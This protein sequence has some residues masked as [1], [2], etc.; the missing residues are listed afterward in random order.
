MRTSSA[1]STTAK[2]HDNNNESL[3]I[4]RRS[5]DC[6]NGRPKAPG[7][8][9][10]KLEWSADT[11]FASS[12]QSACVS[13]AI[14]CPDWSSSLWPICTKAQAAHLDIVV[15]MTND[16]GSRGA[17]FDRAGIDILHQVFPADPA[18]LGPGRRPWSMSRGPLF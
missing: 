13:C 10:R 16:F 8:C 3:G 11:P 6:S 9:G 12:S 1:G 2:C 7:H 17:M 15:D 4:V 5:N 14:S 18:A